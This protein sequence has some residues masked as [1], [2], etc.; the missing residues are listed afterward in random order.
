MAKRTGPTNIVLKKLIE[1]LKIKSV[2][3][4]NT[5]WSRVAYELERPTRSRRVV[6]IH[7]INKYSKP[8][9]MVLVPG[10]VLGNG[11]LNHAVNVIALSF[12]K[13]ALELIGSQKGKCL[14]IQELVKQNPK[15]SEIRILG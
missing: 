6:N 14:T 12:S 11:E 15:V 9:E 4:K 3:D 13:S 10:K 1:E 5:F 8:N 7:R 2:N